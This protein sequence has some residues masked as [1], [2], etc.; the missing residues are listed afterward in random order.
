MLDL[1]PGCDILINYKIICE[2]NAIMLSRGE[3]SF[4]HI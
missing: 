1:I 2:T 3:F 4:M